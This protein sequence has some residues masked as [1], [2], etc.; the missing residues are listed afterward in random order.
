LT[1][2][3]ILEK[4]MKGKKRREVKTKRK[5]NSRTEKRTEITVGYFG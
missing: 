3:L 5:R 4:K 1:D 2:W